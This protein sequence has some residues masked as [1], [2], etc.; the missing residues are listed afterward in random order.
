MLKGIDIS[1]FQAPGSIDFSPYDFVVIRATYG[2]DGVDS[3]VQRHI[4]DAQ[5]SKKLFGFYHYAYPDF[6]N[7][8]AVEAANFLHVVKPYKGQ[9]IL[10]LDWEGEA[11]N[12]PSS[13]CTEFLSI[14]SREMNC[15]PF[16][17]TFA[18]EAAK[19]KYRALA[20]RYPLWLADWGVCGDP[21]QWNKWT[22][23]QY[24]GDPLDLDRTAEFFTKD[25][26]IKY[27]GG[28]T[29]TQQDFNALMDAWLAE[30]NKLPGATWAKPGVE[31]VKKAGIMVGDGSGNFKPKGLV[32][33]EELAQVVSGLINK[34]DGHA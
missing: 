7:T 13:W 11:V 5:K 26:W 14:I 9:A 20:A 10:A 30:Q 1:E 21:G 12:Y 4:A 2:A 24:R 22:I 8:P 23:H 6:G 34:I 29:M 18:A 33:R 28:E 16:F 19:G 17:Y 25:E 3:A 32:R 15:Q 27:A 31:R